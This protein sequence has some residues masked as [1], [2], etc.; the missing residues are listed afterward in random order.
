MIS[1]EL[2]LILSV[3]LIYGLALVWF[4]FFGEKGLLCFTVFTTITA[5][6]E[7]LLVVE[8]FSLEQTL[9]NILFASSFLTTDILSEFYGKKSSKKAVSAG[10]LTSVSFL[11]L[12]QTWLLY[13][14]TNGYDEPFKM[15]FSNTPRIMI[16]SLTVYAISQFLDVW[17]YHKWWSFTEKISGDKRKFLWVRNNGSTLISQFVNSILFTFFA[18]YGVY[19][20]NTLIDIF[21]ASYIIFIV[22]TILDTPAIY[23]ARYLYEKKMKNKQF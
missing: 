7:V 17:L 21:V 1:N 2:L 18:F 16:S 22:T 10:I 8:A 13:N 15:L 12:S 5:N 23:I 6:I 4:Y 3:V 9:G 19:D 11:I 14:V 20:F